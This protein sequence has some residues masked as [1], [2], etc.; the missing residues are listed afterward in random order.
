MDGLA[1]ARLETIHPALVHF[2]LGGLP[3][4]VLAYAVAWLGRRDPARAARWGFVGDAALVLTAALSVLTFA[5]GLVSNAQL[6]WPEGLQRFRLLHL[7]GG[8]L[9]AVLLVGLAVARVLARRRAV[10]PVTFTA[11]A[12]SSLLA[13]GVGWIGG[14]VLVFHGGMA[15]RAAA[16]GM[17]SPPLE[18]PGSGGQAPANLVQA[19]DRLR[20]SWSALRLEQARMLLERPSDAA[21]GRLRAEAA[22]LGAI[23]GWIAAEEPA[24]WNAEGLDGGQLVAMAE[25]LSMKAP[26]VERAAAKQDL[27]AVTLALGQ[28]DAACG[29]CHLTLRWTRASTMAPTAMGAP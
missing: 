11:A 9:V 24:R 12:L 16:R 28:T 20:A 7:W 26:L 5:F 18:A 3:L 22:R 2:T 13:L 21:F 14:E 17:L 15:V 19:M 6:A 8:A 4:M 29:G 23:A 27:V 10:G 25:T 1:I